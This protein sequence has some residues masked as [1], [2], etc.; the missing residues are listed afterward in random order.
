MSL[1]P[2]HF[3][4]NSICISDP[5]RTSGTMLLVDSGRFQYNGVGPS[6]VLHDEYSRTRMLCVLFTR[7]DSTL[8]ALTAM[9]WFNPFPVTSAPAG[10][11]HAHNTLTIDGKEQQAAPATTTVP[12]PNSS[13][14][15]TAAVDAVQGSMS[16]YDGLE[17]K[18][19]HSRSVVYN[20]TGLPTPFFV[21]VDRVATDRPRSVQATWHLHPN[22]SA[23][24][25]GDGSAM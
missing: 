14:T 8:V 2:T 1:A 20:R 11:T 19:C 4:P 22:G 15:F 25:G 17:G 7:S 6:R 10:T 18:A 3:N 5:P 21:V 12:R 9:H 13:W 24:L 16:L 23:T